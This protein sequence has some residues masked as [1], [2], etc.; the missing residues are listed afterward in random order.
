MACSAS[1]RSLRSS[2]VSEAS[3]SSLYLLSVF[4]VGSV[5]LPPTFVAADGRGLHKGQLVIR[6]QGTAKEPQRARTARRTRH[7]CRI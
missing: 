2:F 3:S 6:M 7:R 1:S 4:S 5:G